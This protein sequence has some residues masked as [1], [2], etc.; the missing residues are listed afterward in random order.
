MESIEGTGLESVLDHIE[1]RRI[2]KEL[3]HLVEFEKQFVDSAK[4]TEFV[5]SG[6]FKFLTRRQ[7]PKAINNHS[8][9][10]LPPQPIDHQTPQ[11]LDRPQQNP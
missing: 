3:E 7:N 1:R 4:E 10:R 5:I 6:R 9:I 2:R 11:N 8:L